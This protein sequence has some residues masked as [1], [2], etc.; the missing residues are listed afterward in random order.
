MERALRAATI[1]ELEGLVHPRDGH[2]KILAMIEGYIDETG[3]HD[4]ATVCVIAGYFGGRGQ[5]KRFEHDWRLALKDS[6]V[7]LADFHALNFMKRRKFFF[8]WDDVRH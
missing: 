1:D 8:G 6:E 4:G 5:W 3:I 2:P 7:P